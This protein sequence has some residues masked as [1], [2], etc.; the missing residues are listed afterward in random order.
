MEKGLEIRKNI[1]KPMKNLL[2]MYAKFNMDIAFV[3]DENFS[4]SIN[5]IRNTK[6]WK[7]KVRIILDLVANVESSMVYI[8]DFGAK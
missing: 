8:I 6:N 1:P 4:F 2:I 7:S 3:I 5:F